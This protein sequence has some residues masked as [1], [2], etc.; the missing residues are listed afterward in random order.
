MKGVVRCIIVASAVIGIVGCGPMNSKQLAAQVKEEMQR[1]L[2]KREFMETLKVESVTLV[3]KGGNIYAGVATGT[4]Y[5]SPIRFDVKC[6]YDGTSVLWN[7]EPV[8]N[9]S[10]SLFGRKYGTAAK[11]SFATN[12]PIFK[13]EMK[14][15]YDDAAK[16]CGETYDAAARKSGQWYAR[17]KASYDK[18]KK[19]CAVKYDEMKA[20]FGGPQKAAGASEAP[21]AIVVTDAGKFDAAVKANDY[22]ALLSMAQG[23]AKDGK[24]VEL[25]IERY[26]VA[27]ATMVNA[28]PPEKEACEFLLGLAGSAAAAYD[29][30]AKGQNGKVY[31]RMATAMRDAER[32]FSSGASNEVVKAAYKTMLEF[33]MKEGVFKN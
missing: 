22:G 6:E 7:A 4:V 19:D 1:D 27:F 23:M 2:V 11:E 5:E 17:A 14:R 30:L 31:S 33:Q 28:D 9:N 25:A 24:S 20:R 29:E 18:A 15:Q 8:G 16:K 26:R 12:W 21:A 13:A 32:A 3:H 10:V